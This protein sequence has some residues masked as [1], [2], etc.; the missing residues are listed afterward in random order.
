MKDRL[1]LI[2]LLIKE[3]IQLSDED[4]EEVLEYARFIRE[5][6]RLCQARHLPK[7]KGC[8]DQRQIDLFNGG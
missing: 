8:K 3:F 1:K 7:R 4:Q 6:E 2:Q 5:Q